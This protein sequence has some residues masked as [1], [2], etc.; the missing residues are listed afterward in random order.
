M[1]NSRLE[2]EATISVNVRVD[3]TGFGPW[4]DNDGN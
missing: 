4:I 2:I 1:A 3:T